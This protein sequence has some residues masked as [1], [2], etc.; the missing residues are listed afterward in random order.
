MQTYLKDFQIWNFLSET[1][2]DDTI[3]ISCFQTGH[4]QNLRGR[5]AHKELKN[6]KVASEAKYMSSPLNTFPQIANFTSRNL[7]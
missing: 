1:D 5:L 7:H 6:I 4:A 2:T 3:S